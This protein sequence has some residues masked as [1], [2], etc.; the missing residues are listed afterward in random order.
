LQIYLTQN[1][2]IAQLEPQ[3]ER[4]QSDESHMH[5]NTDVYYHYWAALQYCA[6]IFC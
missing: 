2:S 5:F 4:Q 3:E 1:N 6:R